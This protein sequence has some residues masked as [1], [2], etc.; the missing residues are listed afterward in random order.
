MMRT[1]RFSMPNS[2]LPEEFEGDIEEDERADSNGQERDVTHAGP[3]G[4][5]W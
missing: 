2:H 5:N 3:A 1:T 4:L